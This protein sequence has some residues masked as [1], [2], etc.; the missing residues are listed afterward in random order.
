MPNIG[1][2]DYDA[3]EEVAAMDAA[4]VAKE[5]EE[6]SNIKGL[7]ARYVILPDAECNVVNTFM[8]CC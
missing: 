6:A 5:L 8:K 1:Q 7:E 2:A 3:F 4:T